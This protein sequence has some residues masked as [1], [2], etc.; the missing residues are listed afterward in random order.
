MLFA[1]I[2]LILKVTRQMGLRPWSGEARRLLRLIL[3]VARRIPKEQ[4]VRLTAEQRVLSA[5]LKL[6]QSKKARQRI[7]D[8][9]EVPPAD[10][11]MFQERL[12]QAL[13]ETVR[14]NSAR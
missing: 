13:E 5:A 9:L 8:A 1:A 14:R 2:K 6:A 10:A 7:A 12:R 4:S 11:W 3:S